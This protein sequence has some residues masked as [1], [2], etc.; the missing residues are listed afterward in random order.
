MGKKDHRLIN[1]KLTRQRDQTVVSILLFRTD[2]GFIVCKTN[3]GKST[4]I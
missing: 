3:E 1:R 2:G 4:G